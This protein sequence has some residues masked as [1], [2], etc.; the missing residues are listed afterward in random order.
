VGVS[1][2]LDEHSAW[3]YPSISAVAF[4]LWRELGTLAVQKFQDVYS[5]HGHIQ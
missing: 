4:R 5:I 1:I 2:Q 3:T